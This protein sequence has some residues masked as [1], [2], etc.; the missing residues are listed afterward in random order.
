M[1]QREFELRTQGRSYEQIKE[2]NVR[3]G[4]V[5]FGILKS[6]H[7]SSIERR[8]KNPLYWGFFHLNGDPRRYEGRHELFIPKNILKVVKAINDGNYRECQNVVGT[9]SPLDG[10]LWCHHPECQR[11]ITFDPKPK[12]LKGTG[13]KVVYQYLRCSN[14]RKIHEKLKHIQEGDVMRQFEP[15]VDLLSITQQFAED[16]RKA[17]NETHEKQKAFTTKWK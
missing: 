12:T 3:D 2:E 16:I 8:L 9:S 5:P 13:E 11:K 4:I 7:R 10:W 14:S 6:Y 1:I 15:A 17:L